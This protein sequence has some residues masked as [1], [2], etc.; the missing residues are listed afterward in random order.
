MLVVAPIALFGAL[1]MIKW[2][3]STFGFRSTTTRLAIAAVGM[4]VMVPVF[5][6]LDP[7]LGAP[8]L[9]IVIEE[10]CETVGITLF[11]TGM[12]VYLRHRDWLRLPSDPVGT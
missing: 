11:L 2:L 7:R 4:W 6:A 5:E 10:T 12:L 3:G 1:R 8:R 9:P